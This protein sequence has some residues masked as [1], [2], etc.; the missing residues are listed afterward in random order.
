MLGDKMNNIRFIL[1]NKYTKPVTYYKETNSI[2]CRVFMYFD[3]QAEGAYVDTAVEKKDDVN[4]NKLVQLLKIWSTPASALLAGAPSPRFVKT[5]LPMSL[6][7]PKI[8]ETAKVIY[9]ARDPRDV[10]VSCYHHCRLFTMTGYIGTFKEF[11]NLFHQN[12]CK[13]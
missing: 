11:W 8:L 4:V 10:I 9:L 3:D 7:P 2:D 13:L 1:R 5:H 6:M 12:M